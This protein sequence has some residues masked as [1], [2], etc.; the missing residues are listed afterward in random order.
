MKRKKGFTTIEILLVLGIIGIISAMMFNMVGR[1]NTQRSRFNRALNNF[2]GDFN[3]M[4]SKAS[5]ESRY[6]ALLLIPMASSI[7]SECRT[8]SVII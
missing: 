1:S 5:A 7:L 6:V 4:K 2:V 3:F 8:L